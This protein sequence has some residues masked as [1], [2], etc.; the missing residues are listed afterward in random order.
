MQQPGQEDSSR[1]KGNQSIE[2]LRAK[3]NRT[4]TNTS[5]TQVNL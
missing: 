4:L 2:Q 5:D 3:T 1:T